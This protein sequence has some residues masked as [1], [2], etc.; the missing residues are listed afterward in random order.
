MNSFLRKRIIDKKS[1]PP[2]SEKIR[3]KGAQDLI[4]AAGVQTGRTEI[5]RYTQSFRP[6][7]HAAFRLLTLKLRGKWEG[8]S[9]GVFNAA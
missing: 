4:G 7:V 9:Q 2:V 1:T 3:Q 8:V 5:G 6:S